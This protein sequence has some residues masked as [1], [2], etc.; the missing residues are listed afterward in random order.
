MN[1][2]SIGKIMV[3]VIT[4]FSL[5]CLAIST[6][7]FGTS[8]DWLTETSDEQKSIDELKKKL[9][10]TTKL[11]DEAQKS[12]EDAKVELA[13]QAKQIG[14]RLTAIEEENKRDLIQIGDLR[15]Q[16]AK[17]QDTA[18]ATLDQV[19]A[20]RKA[21]GTLLVEKD[22]VEKQAGDYKRHRAELTDRI[23]DVE[24]ML[25]AAT[26]RRASTK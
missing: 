15:T 4:A 20:K 25:E 9:G 23:R 19:E 3:I 6:V 13:D 2:T 10:E 24:R 1:T 12:L 26:S 7:V 16:V 21:I 11:A 17:A 22:A 18:R 5:T 8:R 14:S